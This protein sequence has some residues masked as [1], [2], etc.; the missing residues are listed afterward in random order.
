MSVHDGISP[1]DQIAFFHCVFCTRNTWTSAVRISDGQMVLKCNKCGKVSGTQSFMSTKLTDAI[2]R[3]NP[4]PQ[5]KEV[6]H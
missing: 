6:E 1:D 2:S 4:T 3:G 5:L